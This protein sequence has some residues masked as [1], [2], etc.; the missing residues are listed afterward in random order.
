MLILLKLWNLTRSR[1]F[2]Y[3][4]FT[5]WACNLCGS[6]FFI[7]TFTELLGHA[8]SVQI[9]FSVSIGKMLIEGVFRQMIAIASSLILFV[10]RLACS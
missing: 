9:F 7:M 3:S 10:F 2:V 6:A 5:I 4:Q 8:L 1:H